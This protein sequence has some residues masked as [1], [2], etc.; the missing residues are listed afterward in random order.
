MRTVLFLLAFF[1]IPAFAAQVVWKWVDDNG[2]THYSDRP[3][4]GATKIEIASGGDRSATSASTPSL[5]SSS[6]SP[7]EAQEMPAYRNFEI[8]KPADGESFVNTGGAVPVNIRVEPALQAGHE[9]YLYLDGRLVEG[10]EPSATS[11]E[12]KEVPR[13]SHRLIAVIND[14][15]GGRVKETAPVAFFVRQESIANPPVGPAL[16]PPPKPT[17]RGAA[18]KLLT[19]QPTYAALNDARTPIDPATNLPVRKAAPRKPGPKSGS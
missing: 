7:P 12:L 15:R 8:W 4:A 10:F 3:V 19:K 2:V 1:A 17:P 13:G 6:S 5:P 16:R 9:L 11:Y 18:N 14:R